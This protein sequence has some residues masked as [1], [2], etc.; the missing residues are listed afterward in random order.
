MIYIIGGAPGS[1]KS[2]FGAWLAQKTDAQVISLDELMKEWNAH[3]PKEEF[4]KRLPVWEAKRRGLEPSPKDYQI[5]AETYWPKI[6]SLIESCVA[7]P[8]KEFV[9]EGAQLSPK[10][11][12]AWLGNLDKKDRNLIRVV[13]LHEEN[14][15]LAMS[16]RSDA[17]KSGFTVSSRSEARARL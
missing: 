14:T 7:H 12:K 17:E 16:I 9:I 2:T 4:A 3:I 5:E 10:L 13:F 11:I 15:P 1:G 6:C 8:K